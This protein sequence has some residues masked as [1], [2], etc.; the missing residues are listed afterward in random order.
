MLGDKLCGTACEQD[1]FSERFE[2][3]K[4]VAC[5]FQNFDPVVVALTDT[6]GFVVLPGV[7]DVSAPVPDHVSNMA[8][9]GNFGGTVDIEPFSQLGTLEYRHGHII[10]VVEALESLIGFIQIRIGMQELFNPFFN[11]RS[12]QIIF[13]VDSGL[14][15]NKHAHGTLQQPVVGIRW[16]FQIMLEL[17]ADLADTVVQ[18]F[19]DMEH[20][21]ADDS[22][23]KDFPCHR[24]KDVVY[25]TAVKANLVAFRFGKLVEVFFEVDRPNYRK[26]IDHGTGITINDVG[27]VFVFDPV[28]PVTDTAVA[29]EL[30]NSDS[31]WELAYG[32]KADQVADEVDDGFRY[33]VFFCHS[34]ERLHFRQ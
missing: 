21:D 20:I 33:V 5:S 15:G 17:T 11:N 3:V 4:P 8:H 16:W 27:V 24:D 18:M 12:F 7:L 14:L 23:G 19:D 13:G 22:L 26:D 6:V 29:F 31:L 1:T 32:I 2:I 9:F 30:I 28:L 34:S 25:V 10:Y